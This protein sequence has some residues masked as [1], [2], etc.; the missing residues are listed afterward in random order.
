MALLEAK[1]FAELIGKP[2][3]YLSVY[4]KRGKVIIGKNGLIDTNNEKNN[5]FILK[6]GGKKVNRVK[7]NTVIETVYAEEVFEKPK[8]KAKVN[9]TNQK[10]ENETEEEFQNIAALDKKKLE[11][12]VKKKQAD[13]EAVL[14]KNAKAKGEVIPFELMKPLIAQN[15]QSLTTAFKN[16]AD[17]VLAAMAKKKNFSNT[18]VAELNGVLVQA[19]NTAIQ[20]A[21]NQSIKTLEILINEYQLAIK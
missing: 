9:L 3:N 21:T 15:N 19:I 6:Q 18:E 11:L 16:A 14:I 10:S 13:L 20:K 17:E 8:I 4:I 12:D 5:A 2:T 7:E 1:E